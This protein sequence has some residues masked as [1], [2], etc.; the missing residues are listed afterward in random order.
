MRSVTQRQALLNGKLL[1]SYEKLDLL[2][3][4]L[5][6]ANV[7]EVAVQEIAVG[8]G[9]ASAYEGSLFDV[10]NLDEADDDPHFAIHPPHC[11][12]KKTTSMQKLFCSTTRPVQL[13]QSGH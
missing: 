3:A 7:M 6:F 5:A 11:T 9:D 12:R 13:C 4:K 10:D 8:K 1:L 2:L